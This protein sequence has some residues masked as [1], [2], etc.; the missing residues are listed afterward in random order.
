MNEQKNILL[1][2]ELLILRIFQI[3]HFILP[4]KKTIN[5]VYIFINDRLIRQDLFITNVFLV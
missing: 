5:R 1:F 3:F 2:I 4:C